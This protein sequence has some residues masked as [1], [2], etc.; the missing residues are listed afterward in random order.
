MSC[1][2]F[3][4]KPPLADTVDNLCRAVKT[5]YMVRGVCCISDGGASLHTSDAYDE[6]TTAQLPECTI[7]FVVE[8]GVVW[9]RLA[10]FFSS[11]LA[12]ICQ[13]PSCATDDSSYD[14]TSWYCLCIDMFGP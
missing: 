6:S 13:P 3:S 1:A 11:R 9:V 14:H 2:A 12:W 4:H 8:L 5:S 10:S 7:G